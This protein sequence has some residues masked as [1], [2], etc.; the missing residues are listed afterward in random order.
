[1]GPS[2]AIVAPG[3]SIPLLSYFRL[4]PSLRSV[5]PDEFGVL[6]KGGVTWP[7]LLEWERRAVRP[8][9][10]IERLAPYLRYF[11]T[12]RPVDDHG[13]LPTV[14][15]VFEDELAAARFVLVVS[16][17]LSRTGLE[18]PLLV[19]D[20]ASVDRLGPLGPAWRRAGEW[21]LGNALPTA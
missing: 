7:F 20:T 12:H 18:P 19:S 21:T 3:N 15:V 16:G 4:G 9:T 8:A 2:N 5:N 6:S 11:A 13:V 17:E 1:M 14:L 10:M